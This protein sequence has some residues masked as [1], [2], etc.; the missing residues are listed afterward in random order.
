MTEA[1]LA[2]W[3]QPK[4]FE[5]FSRWKEECQPKPVSACLQ[6]HYSVLTGDAE[7]LDRLGY[8]GEHRGVYVIGETRCYSNDT[9]PKF[10]DAKDLRC[11]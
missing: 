7:I 8:C 5:Y 3:R 2:A 11:Y 1:Q 4:D 6:A 9:R 10:W